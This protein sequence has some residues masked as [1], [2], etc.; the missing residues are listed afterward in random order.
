MTEEN[1]KKRGHRPRMFTNPSKVITFRVDE[2]EYEKNKT[3]IRKE[4]ENTI[5]K[6]ISKSDKEKIKK[7]HGSGITKYYDKPKE[8][9]E[10]TT[11]NKSVINSK[12]QKKELIRKEFDINGDLGL[13]NY[14]RNKEKTR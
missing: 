14:S 11:A 5:K 6:V 12:N 8:K 2:K 13:T 9:S 3:E 4:V 1:K 10:K 7:E